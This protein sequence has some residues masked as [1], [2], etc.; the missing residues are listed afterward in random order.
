MGY[1]NLF[2]RRAATSLLVQLGAVNHF[3]WTWR[4][5]WFLGRFRFFAETEI[6]H[7]QFRYEYGDHPVAFFEKDWESR[8]TIGKNWGRLFQTGY[9]VAWETIEASDPE[10]TL[11]GQWRDRFLSLGP[12]V[13]WDSRDWPAYP[14]SGVF[15]RLWHAQNRL[16][17]SGKHFDRTGFDARFFCRAF[18]RNILAFQTA[19][20]ISNGMVPVVRRL[21]IGGGKTLRGIENGS[22]SGESAATAT[23][24]YR[25]PI[26]FEEDQE[27][28]FRFGYAA[29]AF[30][31]L[32]A[33]WYQ[34]ESLCRDMLRGSV[35]FG[36][37]GIV[38]GLVLRLEWGTRGNGPGF[39]STGTGVKF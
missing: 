1:N 29:V 3:A 26:L 9:S 16:S 37:H 39:I 12:F 5:P 7:R 2:G 24:E 17:D 34:T 6:H 8:F 18:G 15:L 19:G 38:G 28:G 14:F 22:I 33:A 11:S 13:Q 32:G 21:H 31:D 35:G 10:A 36:F 25:M 20:Q 4:E 30:A 23:V 27:S